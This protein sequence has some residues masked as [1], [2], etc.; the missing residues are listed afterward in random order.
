M[1]V[2]KRLRADALW[3]DLRAGQRDLHLLL[4][5]GGALGAF[6]AGQLIVLLL[7][8]EAAYMLTLERAKAM[9]SKQHDA[10]DIAE[11]MP[12]V[13]FNLVS[14]SGVSAGACNLAIVGS[15]L[16]HSQGKLER[17]EA[18]ARLL[19]FWL[20]DVPSMPSQLFYGRFSAMS[21]L[22]V[23]MAGWLN[24]MDLMTKAIPA[25]INPI[26]QAVEKHADFKKIQQSKLK[27][28]VAVTD[29]ARDTPVVLTN[30]ALTARMIAASGAID[31]WGMQPVDGLGEGAYH[32]NPF[33]PF[34]EEAHG[35]TVDAP[36]CALLLRLDHNLVAPKKRDSQTQAVSSLVKVFH[37]PIKRDIERI[38][39]VNAR[40]T[41]RVLRLF[42]SGLQRRYG[43]TAQD[44]GNTDADFTRH[45]LD[46]GIKEGI[47][48]LKNMPKKRV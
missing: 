26:M 23:T 19:Q 6:Q 38:R 3:R 40:P 1:Y 30:T 18:A 29:I 45:A 48:M 7:G 44:K 24:Y 17:L 16:A 8:E 32:H 27:M 42:E 12:D 9:L 5:G 25:E 39:R 13:W 46:C 21:K 22:P 43:F 28:F 10:A 36:I 15:A 14:L 34:L 2:P 4:T 41:G 37:A 35:G 11:V 47:S 31:Q 33:M 20:S